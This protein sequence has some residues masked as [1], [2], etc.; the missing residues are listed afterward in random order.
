M[1]SVAVSCPNGSGSVPADLKQ[2]NWRCFMY[3]VLVENRGDNRFEATTSDA[4]FVMGVNGRGANPVETVLAGLCGCVGHYVRDFCIGHG[5]DCPAFTLRGEGRKA[6][7]MKRLGEIDLFLNLEGT[8]L[9]ERD[10][11]ALQRH[12]EKCTIH[13]T[14]RE[15]C[16]I[17]LSLEAG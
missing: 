15:V 9:N 12:V 11:E 6:P 3:R 1:V 4:A 5:I 8:T 14:L 13:A 10:T 7:D 16:T 17:R 2:R